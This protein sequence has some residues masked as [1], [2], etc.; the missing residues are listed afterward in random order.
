MPGREEEP[1]LQRYQDGSDNYKG[2]QSTCE[3]DYYLRL[4]ISAHPSVTLVTMPGKAS[5]TKIMIGVGFASI[6]LTTL[7]LRPCLHML[8][9]QRWD[10]EV[11]A[12]D[13]LMKH[14]RQ[15][16]AREVAAHDKLVEYRR[17]DWAREEAYHR[18]HWAQEEADHRRQWKQ[19]EADHQQRR[20][21]HMQEQQKWIAEKAEMDQWKTDLERKRKDIF[22]GDYRDL[23]CSK[24]SKRRHSATLNNVLAGLNPRKECEVKPMYIDDGWVLPTWCEDTVGAL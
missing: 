6:F 13:K 15:D 16:W 7:L 9:R 23:G 11:A 19:E 1:L 12:H 5:F 14:H 8:Q 20:V 17:Q 22:W 24:Y 21:A 3:P 4:S 10:D 2:T 18:Q